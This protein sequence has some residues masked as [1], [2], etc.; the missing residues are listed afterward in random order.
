[1]VVLTPALLGMG[2]GGARAGLNVFGA[3]AGNRA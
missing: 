3:I 2:L 1:M